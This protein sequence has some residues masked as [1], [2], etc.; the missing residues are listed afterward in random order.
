MQI[1]YRAENIIDANLV[2]NA[3][4][5]AGIGAFV[6]GHYL[7]GAAG[8]LPVSGLVNV[9]VTESEWR[10]ARAIAERIDVELAERRAAPEF[11]GDWAAD[12][13]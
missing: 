8:E 12:A 1:V 10:R 13:V 11:D 7:T 9:M 4:A 2:G 6:S 3:L 5:D